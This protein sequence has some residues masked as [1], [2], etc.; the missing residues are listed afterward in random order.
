MAWMGGCYE[1]GYSQNPVN[2]V[3]VTPV[4]NG[5]PITRG[6]SGYVA[7]DEWYFDIHFRPNDA[8]VVPI[9]TGKLPREAQDKVLAWAY[10]RP[11]GGRGFG[12]AGG[13][14]TSNWHMEPFRKLVLNAILWVAKAEV[15]KDG[16]CG[17]SPWRFV[18]MADFPGADL[19]YPQPGWEDTL[20]YILKAVKAENPEFVLVAGDLV[21]GHWP[22]KAAIEKLA[23]SCYPAWMKRM[24]DH[25]L[26]FYAT[27]GDH[28]IGGGPWPEDKAV[29]AVLLKRQFQ[30]YL[31]MP[32][33][34][35]LR[36]KGTAFSFVH[37]NA[38]FVALDVFERGAG[39]QAGIVPQVTGEQLQWLEQ[40]LAENPGV[41]HVV[42][43][44][45]TPVL[46]PPVAPAGGLM[47][48]GGR[49]S[50]LW[51]T[52]QKHSVDLYLCGETQTIGCA[53]ADG[54]L[55]IAHGGLATVNYTVATVYP[56]RID[57][58]VKKIDVIREGA[59]QTQAGSGLSSEKLRIADDVKTQGFT[60]VGTAVLHRDRTGLIL[61]NITGVLAR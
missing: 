60:T 13:H 31:N 29:L 26:K 17:V 53:Q 38:L 57:L 22:D 9:M 46:A 1:A 39:P 48:A 2:V 42:V 37:E 45:H 18:S 55:Q 41:S 34:G 43:M 59:G 51:Q 50:P 35:P 21:A 4:G 16:V 11:G 40:T 52:L 27:V 28:E 56:D 12:F 14:Y 33:N 44:G 30:K 10:T 5:H 7:E 23:A 6:C 36:L 54:I 32:R 47:L 3:K 24:E 25:G 8:N 58:E 61:S 15:P 49:Q 20:D 19:A